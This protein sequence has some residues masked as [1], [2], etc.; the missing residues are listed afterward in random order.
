MADAEPYDLNSPSATLDRLLR[1]NRPGYDPDAEPRIIYVP[2]PESAPA[3]AAAPDA[4]LGEAE[5]GAKAGCSARTIRRLI[6][7]GR[8]EATDYGTGKHHNYR[9]AP[10]ALARLNDP[11]PKTRRRCRATRPSASSRKS[12]ASLLP[13]F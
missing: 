13:D 7:T 10:A 3:E 5:A 9:I 1:S 8:L 11:Q 6:A 2:V 12:A 4:L